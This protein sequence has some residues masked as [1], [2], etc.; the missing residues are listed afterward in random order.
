MKKCDALDAFL[1]SKRLCS[2]HPPILVPFESTG[3]K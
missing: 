2:Q 3:V 1:T